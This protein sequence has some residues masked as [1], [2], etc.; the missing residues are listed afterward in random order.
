[1]EAGPEEIPD[2]PKPALN[3]V[4]GIVNLTCDWRHCS[5]LGL[6]RQGVIA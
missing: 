1:M 4:T 5:F 6:R 3:G 2:V